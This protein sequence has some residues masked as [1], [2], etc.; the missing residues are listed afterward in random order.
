[1]FGEININAV[2]E[3]N[4]VFN[5]GGE[6][7]ILVYEGELY[8]AA[9]LCGELDLP[10]DCS[11]AEIFARAYIKWRE[12][13]L[14]RFNGS[15]ALA[16]YEKNNK[17]F[18]CARDKIGIKPFFYSHQSDNFIFASDVKFILEKIP[19]V[20]NAQ[21][22]AEII[23]IGPGRTPGYGIFKNIEELEPGFYGIFVDGKFKK[24][25]YWDL[26]DKEHTD[27]FG[28]TV[29]KVRGLVLDAISRRLDNQ[30]CTLLSGGLDS[31][32]ITSVAAKYFKDTGKKLYAFSVDYQDNSKYFNANIF[33]PESDGKYIECMKNYL[34]GE[35]FE[36]RQI[37]LDTEQLVSALYAAVEARGLPG[38]ADIDASFLLLCGEIKKIS[39]SALSGEGADEIFGGYPWF[40][41]KFIREKYGFPW[42]QSTDFRKT[43]FAR[44]F[45]YLKDTAE[46]YVNERYAAAVGE[47]PIAVNGAERRIKELVSLN[48][49]WFMQTL[50]ERQNKMSGGLIIRAPY[51]DYRLA[52]YLYNVP[53]EYKDYNNAEKGLL[54]KAVQGLLPEQVLWRK[55][56]PYPK[57]HNPAYLNAV[58]KILAGIINEPSSPLLKIADKH[59][60][61]NLIALAPDIKWYGQLMNSPQTIAYF[62]QINHWL[63]KYKI[64]I[65]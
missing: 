30:A 56:S 8:N 34:D 41:D 62:V 13:S 44:D 25:K 38:M 18:F 19:A 61:A 27:N 24:Y 59:A 7:Y 32:L 1:M 39:P 2:L 47:P 49:K 14:D 33:Q 55:K 60:L 3:N 42:S 20:I 9:E 50:L 48:M 64:K 43:F 26:A 15:F 65:I 37:I 6:N 57:T 46:N 51:C 5:H 22:V 10:P 36:H 45:I 12:K 17:R 63:D 4:I 52:E 54:R 31:S 35:Y 28:Q 23:L 40:R 21:S 53:W 16:I 58:S 29:E 11:E